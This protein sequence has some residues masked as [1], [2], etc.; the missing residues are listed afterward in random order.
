MKIRGKTL[1][2]AVASLLTVFLLIPLSVFAQTET[3]QLTIKATDPQHA[4]VAGATVTVK[5]V[6]RGT[7]VNATTNDEGIAVVPSLQPG[8][9]DVTVTGSGF[10]PYAAKA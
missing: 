10:A 5:S 4:V 9:Y 1:R 2:T 8:I 6:D 7:V 3:G